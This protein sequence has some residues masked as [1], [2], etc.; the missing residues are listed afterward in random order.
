MNVEFDEPIAAFGSAFVVF[1]QSYTAS[2]LSKN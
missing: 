1:V 2:F